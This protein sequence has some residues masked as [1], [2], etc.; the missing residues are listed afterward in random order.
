L[1]PSPQSLPPKKQLATEAV[2]AAVPFNTGSN[3]P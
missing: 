1:P 2:V 3:P